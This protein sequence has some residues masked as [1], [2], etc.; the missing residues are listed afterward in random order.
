MDIHVSASYNLNIAY[1]ILN[2]GSYEES[3]IAFP[4]CGCLHFAINIFPPICNSEAVN[5][6]LKLMG[7]IM[8]LF[9]YS[10]RFFKKHEEPILQMFIQPHSTDLLIFHNDNKRRPPPSSSASCSSEI[11]GISSKLF[12]S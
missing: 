1:L 3:F 7:Y 12:E 11:S 6:T 9:H 8:L 5:L 2:Y 4:I 10:A